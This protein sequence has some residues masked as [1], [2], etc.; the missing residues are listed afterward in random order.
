MRTLFYR[1]TALM[2]VVGSMS[3][4]ALFVAGAV[5]GAGGAIYVNG[6]SEKNIA[7]PVRQVATATRLV[8]EDM[9]LPIVKD[10]V[11]VDSANFESE[12]ADGKKVWIEIKRKTDQTS[13]MGVRVSVLGDQTRSEDIIR[14][15]EAKL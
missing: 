8:L 9:G 4:C 11:D 10:E 12:Y 6:R 7:A 5:A 1:G 2:L 13:Y 15:V 3:G 14:R